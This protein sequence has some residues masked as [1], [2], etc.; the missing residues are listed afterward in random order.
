[1]VHGKSDKITFYKNFYPP[2]SWD[3]VLE[4]SP[5]TSEYYAHLVKAYGQAMADYYWNRRYDYERERDY[6]YI[7]ICKEINEKCEKFLKSRGIDI[8]NYK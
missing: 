7:K 3:K 5:Q 6:E 2:A 8:F 1:M 4:L